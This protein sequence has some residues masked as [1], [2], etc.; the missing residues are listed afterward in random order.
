MQTGMIAA[1]IR[2]VISTFTN[3]GGGGTSLGF[4]KSGRFVKNTLGSMLATTILAQFG[5]LALYLAILTR[6]VVTLVGF[7]SCLNNITG[8]SS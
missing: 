2:F 6:T 3:D 1:V 5:L 4:R 8:Q 7:L